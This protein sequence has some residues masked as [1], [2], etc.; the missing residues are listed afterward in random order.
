MKIENRNFNVSIPTLEGNEVAELVPIL[1]PMEWDEEI[2]EWLMTDEG[3]KQVE[4]TK[5]RHMGLLLPSEM[6]A[7]RKRL[8][9][10]Q[11]EIGQLLQ[12]GEKTWNRWETGKGR[13]S[14]SVNLLLRVLHDRDLSIECLKRLRI[15][16][17]SWQKIIPSAPEPPHFTMD[18]LY[19]RGGNIALE[20]EKEQAA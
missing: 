15:N 2:G 19:S 8:G 6:L 11:E 1:I 20:D 14:R 7:L 18:A 16:R 9:L 4:E 17:T 12:I 5:A 3:L 13:P 10:T